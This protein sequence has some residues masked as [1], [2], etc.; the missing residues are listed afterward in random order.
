[1]I[2][3]ASILSSVGYAAPQL[4]AVIARNRQLCLS[5]GTEAPL[6][7]T[8][9]GAWA[10]RMIRDEYEHS[11]KCANDLWSLAESS[12]R[13]DLKTEAYVTLTCS[14]LWSGR[15]A[16]GHEACRA[17]LKLF[18]LESSKVYTR[19][20]GQNA[21]V[22]LMQFKS[23]SLFYAGYPDQARAS[24]VEGEALAKEV[25]HAFSSS[26]LFFHNA[27]TLAQMR[28]SAGSVEYSLRGEKLAIEHGFPFW[29][30][31]NRMTLGAGL[32]LG[33]EKEAARDTLID[34]ITRTRNT[35]ANSCIVS[36]LSFL[37]EAYWQCG[38]SDAARKTLEQGFD[39]IKRLGGCGIAEVDLHVTAS[40]FLLAE[41]R[42]AEAREVAGRALAV[43]RKQESPTLE[44]RAA[45]ALARIDGAA[46]V[47]EGSE[48][49]LIYGLLTE[50]GDLPES[51]EAQRLLGLN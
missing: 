34:G 11:I 29:I 36:F 30:G 27:F 28:D 51:L 19:Y 37:A 31:M 21:G 23:M 33:G 6:F 20:S 8:V 40:R 9:W 1:M 48:L 26:C 25:S 16:Q 32:L 18:H 4:E 39:Q 38:E 44:L 45:L 7:A 2:K 10:W 43:A 5:I 49:A 46:F 15:V 3:H 24:L 12:G 50:G 13:D 14:Y 47:P 22:M 42:H 17:G 35:G 41:E